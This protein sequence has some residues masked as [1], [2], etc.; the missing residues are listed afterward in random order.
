MKT[1]KITNLVLATICSAY[2]CGCGD[3]DVQPKN[4]VSDETVFSSAYGISA[5]FANLYGN[6]RME[7]FLFT[8]NEGYYNIHGWEYRPVSGLTG[9]FLCRDIRSCVYEDD[10]TDEGYPTWGPAFKNLRK[11][12]YFLKNIENYK[13]NLDEAF[14][15][16]VKG[17]ALFLRAYD[18]FELVKRYGGVP[19]MKEIIDYP[20]CG[21]EG[22]QLPRNS[23]EE[24]WDFIIE[25]AHNAYELMYERPVS[26]GRASRYTAAALESRAAL[27]AGTIAEYNKIELT[28]PATGKR[29]CGVPSEK[30]KDYF[31]KSIEAARLVEGHA[32]LYNKFPTDK[33]A[34][35]VNLFLDV[36]NPEALLVRQYSKDDGFAHSWQ[37]FML[38]RQVVVEGLG[39][40][41]CPTLD[42][43]EM[44]DGIPKND[45]GT[46]KSFNDDGSFIMYDNRYQPFENAEP[47]LLAYVLVPGATWMKQEIDIRRGIYVGDLHDGKIY[48]SD[49]PLKS[50]EY[51]HYS[52]LD[53][54][55]KV[56]DAGSKDG[57]SNNPY[58]FDDGTKMEPCGMSGCYSANDECAWS[59]FSVR[60][61]M[62]EEMDVALAYENKCEAPWIDMRY[63][64]VMLNRAEA[65]V[66]LA[67]NYGVAD[68]LAEANDMISQIR[69]RAGADP[70]TDPLTVEIVRRER[71]KELA[72]ENKVYWDLMRWR[73]FHLEQDDRHYKQ[74]MPFYVP[75]VG[76]GGN[77]TASANGGKYIYHARLGTGNQFTFNQK[78]YYKAIPG[79]EINSNSALVQNP[80]Y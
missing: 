65:A 11:I 16:H 41:G 3:I 55:G 13:E 49:L 78:Y 36:D 37:K 48:E 79:S 71:R 12:N 33:V 18:Y 76:A 6:C 24:C 2:L 38:P 17:E 8:I 67:E 73:V 42:F 35:L 54:G 29:L 45:D 66:E 69:D 21:F 58:V 14:Y 43:V 19:Y 74:L 70:L 20:S 63:A 77:C 44:F 72:F 57:S 61:F 32:S 46:W 9:E 59:G 50:N 30:A 80:G 34:N 27:F 4:M 62:D 23:E 68:Y 51:S 56:Y 1:G 26:T 64:E 25:D 22:T 15:N 7:D 52:N 28:D 5:Y 39:S 53:S 75:P 31:V 60:K 47:R 10:G 40:S